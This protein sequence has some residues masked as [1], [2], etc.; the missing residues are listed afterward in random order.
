MYF[1]VTIE[2]GDHWDAERSLREQEQWDAHAALMD[3]L[4]DEGFIVLGGPLDDGTK[5][6]LIINAANQQV[7]EERLS[8]DLWLRLGVRRIATIERW[9][10]LL[11]ARH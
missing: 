5:A 11:D 10:I 7:I 8:G 4:V 3:A 2:S 9:E 1:V 6:L